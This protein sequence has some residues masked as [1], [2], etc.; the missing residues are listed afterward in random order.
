MLNKQELRT[1]AII[2]GNGNGVFIVLFISLGT[3]QIPTG[4]TC[5]FSYYAYVCREQ[6]RA[7]KDIE[8]LIQQFYVSGGSETWSL[9]K[10]RLG[11]NRTENKVFSND[12]DKHSL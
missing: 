1:V 2:T 5:S 4:R 7:D 10:W 12:K 6:W 11:K 3:L 8:K 9:G